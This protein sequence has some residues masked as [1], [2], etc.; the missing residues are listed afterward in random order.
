MMRNL[1]LPALPSK[2]PRQ[3]SMA[4]DSVSLRGMS[5]SERRTA[6]ARLATLLMEAAGV[7]VEER[8]NDER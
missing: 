4:L 8:D 7:A 5:P 3:L 6:L 1:P 2:P